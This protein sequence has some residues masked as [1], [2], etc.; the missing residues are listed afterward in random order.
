[1][2][3]TVTARL[4]TCQVQFELKKLKHERRYKRRYTKI[5]LRPNVV[6]DLKMMS[7]V[8]KTSFTQRKKPMPPVTVV[9]W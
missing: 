5:L 1:M 9:E 7:E 2:K 3:D 4:T 6:T 8:R